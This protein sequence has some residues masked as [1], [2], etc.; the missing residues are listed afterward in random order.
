MPDHKRVLIIGGVA[1]GASCA[2]RLRRLD[3]DAEIIIFERG[4]HVSFA[5]CGLP[6]YVGKVI[7]EEGDL[8]VATPEMFNRNFRIE[9]R[10]RNE[11]SAIDREKQEIEVKNLETGETY[12]ER[13]DA[14]VLAPGAAPLRPPIPGIGLPGIHILRTIPDSNAIKAWIRERNPKRAVVVG[15]GYIGLE[16][17][18]NLVRRGLD[19]TIV[20]MLP[21]IMPALDP[22]MAEA[23]T[24]H[25]ESK[26]VNVETG[27]GVAAF[28]QAAGGS[29]L[30]KTRRGAAYPADLVIL[31][32]G[33]RPE[34]A[35]ARSAGLE[36]GECGGIRVDEMMRASDPRI[37]AVGDAVETRDIVTGQWVLAPLAGPANRQGRIA[38]EVIAGRDSRF[39]GVQMTSI[40]G[41]LGL[42]VA[43]T[44]ASEKRLRA[45]GITNYRK[46]YVHPG[47]TAMYYPG[48]KR[49]NLKVIFREDDGRIL[50]A[51]CVGENGVDKRIDVLALAIQHG[52]TVYDLEEAELCYA[53]Q[54]GAAKDPVNI[55]GMVAANILRGD[56]PQAD[57]SKLEET[58]AVLVDVRNP[59]EYRSDHID[60]AINIPLG[61]M[62]E[63]YTELPKDRE[64]WINC[65]IGQ[66]AYYAARF[67]LQKGYK[68]KHLSGG[69]ITYWGYY[70]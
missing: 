32:V 59:E 2:A 14:L 60:G 27:D 45:A 66:R 67:L 29:L 9:I 40:C 64:I 58:D 26:R 31:S 1:G 12:R 36:C 53:P 43:A 50:G 28:E 42:T 38:A 55:A 48:S 10:A 7:K 46:V 25:L 52:A 4:P 6:Y 62:R 44:G 65:A 17:T 23:V 68:V 56:L 11:V 41:V 22:E 21:Q 24:Q 20:E 30:V 19:V 33:V 39:R 37:W 15:G 70:S 63:R 34:T 3:E 16:M 8:L 54:Y 69:L 61:E 57:W 5:N 35:L 47:H 13:Y 51:Q 18:E 49:L